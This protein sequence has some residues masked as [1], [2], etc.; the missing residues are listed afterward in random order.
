MER[1][2]RLLESN[3][4][5]AEELKADDPH[6]FE[7]LSESQRPDFLWIGCADSRISPT[8]SIGLLPGEMF[9]H[10]NVANLVN[11][12]DVNCLAV[13]QFA[14]EVLIRAPRMAISQPAPKRHGST[15]SYLKATTGLT[16]EARHAG[17]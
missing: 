4:R 7:R 10:R 15:H 12:S 14:I 5:W 11:H 9:V 1:I 13:M 16:R 8:S 6:F 17:R 2:E 3:R